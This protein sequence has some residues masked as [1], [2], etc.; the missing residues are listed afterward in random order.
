MSD[1]G[2]ASEKAREAAHDEIQRQIGWR[3]HREEVN[4][5]A[6]AI[7]D[8]A[9]S[10]ALGLERSVNERWMVERVAHWIEQE[11]GA[12]NNATAKALREEFVREFGGGAPSPGL[13]VYCAA[14]NYNAEVRD[15]RCI[16][17]GR[18]SA[19]A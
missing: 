7:L 4:D 18:V 11:A 1:R 16:R 10:E 13:C 15:G 5:R 12:I 17:C 14:G 6:R 2:R 8:A 19:D 3:G 9:H